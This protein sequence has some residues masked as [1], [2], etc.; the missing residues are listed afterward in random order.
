M[1]PA[2]LFP[3]V[4]VLAACTSPSPVG[5]SG[6]L[7]AVFAFAAYPR[8][9]LVQAHA[10]PSWV[11]PYQLPGRSGFQEYAVTDPPTTVEAH[12]RDLAAGHGWTL[13]G[14]F[15]AAAGFGEWALVRDKRHVRLTIAPHQGP[16]WGGYDA[17][18]YAAPAVGGGTTTPPGWSPPPTPAPTPTPGT[19]YLRIEA[20][21][22]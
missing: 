13:T 17:P 14:A 18:I 10:N 19:W 11:G 15:Q 22:P 5:A 6:E 20:N 3:A 12:Y 8:G 2:L 1:R 9:T 7:N 16:A 4:A 21:L